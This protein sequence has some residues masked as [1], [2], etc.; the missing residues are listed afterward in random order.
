MLEKVTMNNEYR[1]ELKEVKAEAIKRRLYTPIEYQNSYWYK[2][3]P[4]TKRK[5]FIMPS[6][7]P[8]PDHLK[9]LI[10]KELLIVEEGMI[11]E[12]ERK[13]KIIK[14]FDLDIKWFFEELEIAEFAEYYVLQKWIGKLMYG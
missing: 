4:Y 12:R 11:S 14:D 3:N 2:I 9:E 10:L 5:Q 13:L 6:R 7:E 1:Q 8:L